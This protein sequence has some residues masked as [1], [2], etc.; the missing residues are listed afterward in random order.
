MVPGD[1]CFYFYCVNFHFHRK[2][3]YKKAKKKV[4]RNSLNSLDCLTDYRNQTIINR[5]KKKYCGIYIAI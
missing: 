1:C 5:I 2:K 4:L 3:L